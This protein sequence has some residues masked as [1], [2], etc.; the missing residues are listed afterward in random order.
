MPRPKSRRRKPN[1]S[2]LLVCE[3]ENTEPIYFEELRKALDLG[4]NLVEVDVH[5]PSQTGHTDPKGL[6]AAA[7]SAQDRRKKEAKK[8]PVLAEYNEVWAIFDTEGLGHPRNEQL[9]E[10]AETARA[11]DISLAISRPSFEV[12]FL[13]HTKPSP[14]GC[15]DCK[16]AIK[17]TK[18]LCSKKTLA[19]YGKT[20]EE[21]KK[22]VGW[23]LSEKR[24]ALAAKHGHMQKLDYPIPQSTGSMVYL[25]VDALVAQCSDA[26]ARISLG[27]DQQE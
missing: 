17:H 22:A 21:T 25:L 16:E 27:F 5:P 13:L 23:C 18:K 11:N 24:T 15:Q 4:A 26:Q 19:G 9:G 14:P 12:W 1:K 7:L 6:I 10:A 20:K 2:F 3:G 8:S